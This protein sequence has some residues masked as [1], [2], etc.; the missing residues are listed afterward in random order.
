VFPPSAAKAHF[1]FDLQAKLENAFKPQ[2]DFG[3]DKKTQTQKKL[4]SKT[5]IVVA[6]VPSQLDDGS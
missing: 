5:V 3:G 6:L 4:F 2:F 1:V